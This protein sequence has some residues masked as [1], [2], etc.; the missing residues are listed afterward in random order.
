[1]VPALFV[2]GAEDP[3]VKLG[4]D[5]DFHTMRRR[6][7]DLR[8]MELLPGAGHFLQQEQPA[9]LNRVLI[10]FLQSL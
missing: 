3:T 5:E 9:A 4:S 2:G 1:M 10:E 6:T 7:R 8:G